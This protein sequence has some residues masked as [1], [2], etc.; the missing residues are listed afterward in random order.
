LAI[1]VEVDDGITS[2]LDV[3]GAHRHNLFGLVGFQIEA[4]VGGA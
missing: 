2:I 4:Q 1:L 3:V